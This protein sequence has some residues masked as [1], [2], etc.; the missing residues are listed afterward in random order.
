MNLIYKSYKLRIYPTKIQEVLLSKHFGSCR[1]I[2]NYYL[3]NRKEIYLKDK[4]SSNYYSD[5]NDLTQLKKDEN[6]AW[7]KEINSQSLQASIR[8]LDIAY[9]NFFNKQ[10]KFPRFKSKYDKQSFKIPQNI[11]IKNDKIFIPKFTEGIKINLYKDIKDIEDKI[12]SVT[13]SKSKTGKYYA[14]INYEMNHDPFKKTGSKVGIDTGIKD[15]AI[16]SDGTIYENIKALKVKLKKLKYEQKQL[17]KKQK[18]GNSRLKQRIKL[19]KIYEKIVNARKDYLHKISTE[20][21]KNHDIICIEDLHVKNMM[22]NHRLAQA[23]SDVSLGT[24]YSMLKYKADWND[25]T[26]VKIDKFFPSSKTCSNCGWINQNLTLN[27]RKWNCPLCKTHHDRDLNAAQN[28][29]R[30][31]LNLLSDSGMESDIKQK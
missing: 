30:Q 15:L 6:L 1:F 12:M 13:I 14:S 17:S 24:F 16:L 19:A 21:I 7:L 23:F 28:I 11:K 9:K 31:G 3:N 18:G 29:L 27:I 20:I 4:K 26:I 2:F 10:S 8:N 25:K 5:A 22:K